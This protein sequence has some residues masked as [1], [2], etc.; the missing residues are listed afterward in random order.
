MKFTYTHTK[1]ACS[2]G[3]V[4]QAI[5]NNFIP[6]L[7]ITFTMEFDMT[8]AQITPLVSINFAVQLLVD[9]L[10]AKYADKLGYR[11]CMVTAHVCAALGLAGL[12]FLPQLMGSPFVGILIP[13]VLYAVGGGLLEVLCSPIVEALPSDHKEASMSFLHAA[14]SWGHMGVILLSTLYFTLAG[15]ENWRY[16]ACLWAVIPALNALAFTTSNC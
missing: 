5:V 7:F 6:L 2:V 16:L 15:I 13:M 4:T 12:S 9:L 3:L 11:T 1:A 14:Y 8:L 10:C